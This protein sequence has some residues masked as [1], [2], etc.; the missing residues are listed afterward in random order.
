M[1]LEHATLVLAGIAMV[2]LTSF[3]LHT[4]RPRE[5]KP[6]S[7]LVKTEARQTFLVIGLVTLAVIGIGLVLQGVLS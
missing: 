2:A 6:V 7:F 4:A 3:V 1:F 5:G